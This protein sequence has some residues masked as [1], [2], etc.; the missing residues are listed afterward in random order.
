MGLLASGA[1]V[2]S[3]FQSNFTPTMKRTLLVIDDNSA[4]RE[5]L[6]FMLLRRGYAVFVAE[7]GMEGL[8]VAE[9]HTIDGAMVDVNMPGMN[10]IEV[11][12][13]LHE[14]AAARGHEISVWVMTGART[15]EITKL[16]LEAGAIEVLSKPFELAALFRR[17]EERFKSRGD[18]IAGA[19]ERRP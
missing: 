7:N 18:D 14:Q 4:V 1:W 8:A 9:Q 17:F 3:T 15:P 10:G 13:G 11:C 5:S 2:G 6:R 16:A 12:R 19:P